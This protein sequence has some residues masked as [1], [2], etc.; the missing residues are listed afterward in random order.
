MSRPVPVCHLTIGVSEDTSY[1]FEDGEHVAHWEA[2]PSRPCIGS[3]CS[4]WEC[5]TES[6]G[7]CGLNPRG[8]WTSPPWLDPA[9][10]AP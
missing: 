10:E 9:R 2:P 7:A 5:V 4:A 1:R 8:P 3:R 6:T